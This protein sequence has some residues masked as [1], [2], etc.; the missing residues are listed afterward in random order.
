MVVGRFVSGLQTVGRVAGGLQRQ[1]TKGSVFAR[2]LGS[3]A[4][5]FGGTKLGGFI[6]ERSRLGG[7]VI[8]GTAEHAPKVASALE[9]VAGVAGKLK[10]LENVKIG[11]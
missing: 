10:E 6:A 9:K 4:T 11:A 2:K 5:E 3:S 1:A 8:R 7:K